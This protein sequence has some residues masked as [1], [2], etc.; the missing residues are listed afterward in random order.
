LHLLRWALVAAL[1]IYALSGVRFVGPTESAFIL[2]LGEL[3][4][5]V[6]DSGLVLAWPK[7]IDEVIIVPTQTVQELRLDGWAP[8]APPD[9]EEIT[10]E[11]LYPGEG[12]ILGSSAANQEPA[13]DLFAEEFGLTENEQ[14]TLL[15]GSTL[16]PVLHGYTLTGD[17]NIVRAE[18][19][20]RYRVVDP[21]K[22]VL[23]VDD[24][25]ALLTAQVY[26]AATTVIASMRVDGV[27]TVEQAVFRRETLELAQQFADGLGLGVDLQTLE[28][29]Q[30]KPA[31]QVLGAF[32]DVSSAQVEARTQLEQARSYADTVVQNAEARGYRARQEAQ[33]AAEEIRGRARGSSSAFLSLQ[34][35]YQQ[36]PEL[37]RLR[38]LNET[39]QKV[40]SSA[41]GRSVLAPESN[42]MRLYL[43]NQS[44]GTMMEDHLAPLP[45]SEERLDTGEYRMDE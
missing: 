36:Q 18:F 15:P 13:A 12:P 5:R 6:Y 39:L 2:R 8:E 31:R 26:R 17:A 28:V 9:P 45:E 37:T 20:V 4:P 11:E 33:A 34:H 32:E 10:E 23:A 38:L 25:V 14:T 16:H 22:W 43:R 1:V 29:L 7:P 30:I 44:G 21:V 27:L 24:P 40:Y 19:S 42:R 41:R 35:E 3:Q